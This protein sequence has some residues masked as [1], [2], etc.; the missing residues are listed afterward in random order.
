MAQNTP[1]DGMR[2]GELSA[3]TGASQRSLRYYEQQGL[4]SSARA[5]SGQRHYGEGHV[6]RVHLIQKFLAAGL[7]TRVI[8]EMVPCM[9]APSAA[10]AHRSLAIMTR[11]QTRISS[12][13]E[14]LTAAHHTLGDLIDVNRAYLADHEDE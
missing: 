2:I 6:T 8:A 3:R 7:S 9:L 12:I 13:I 4:L 10:D 5:A 1:G 11:E 14:G